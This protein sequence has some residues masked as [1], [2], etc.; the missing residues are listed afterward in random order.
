M[1]PD[2]IQWIVVS[3]LVKAHPETVTI[4]ELRRLGP[5]E[6]VEESVARLLIDGLAVRFGEW[7]KASEPA[8]RYD[9][10]A[11]YGETALA[12]PLPVRAA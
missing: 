6:D 5:A 1:Q 8:A 2:A 10:L 3:A 12:R 11:R 4:E 9:Q 7:V